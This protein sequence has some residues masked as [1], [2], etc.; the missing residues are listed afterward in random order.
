MCRYKHQ[1]VAVGDKMYVIGGGCFKPEQSSIDLYVLDL[2]TLVWEETDMTVSETV[3]VVGRFL[4]RTGN[5]VR[6]NDLLTL[7][8]RSAIM[9]VYPALA[10][11]IWL[12]SLKG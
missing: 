10:S 11:S 4:H 7:H 8:P 3:F 2:K 1:A 12:R 9:F 5:C 6:Q